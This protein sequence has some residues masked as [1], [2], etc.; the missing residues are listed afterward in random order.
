VAGAGVTGCDLLGC[1]KKASTGM[2]GGV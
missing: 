2:I 1:G